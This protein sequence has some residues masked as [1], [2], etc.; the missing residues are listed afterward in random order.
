MP[1]RRHISPAAIAPPY[2]HISHS[3]PILLSLSDEK[4]QFHLNIAAPTGTL[5][6]PRYGQ[7]I[8]S[9]LA[10]LFPDCDPPLE[11]DNHVLED[12]VVSI[13][14]R[15]T[16]GCFSDGATELLR[17]LF[18]RDARRFVNCVTRN[19]VLGI[20]PTE[21]DDIQDAWRKVVFFESLKRRDVLEGIEGI[22][23]R[24]NV[25]EWALVLAFA[26]RVGINNYFQRSPPSSA[27][28]ITSNISTNS[29]TGATALSTATHILQ[30]HSLHSNLTE[31]LTP[32]QTQA[33]F[34][35]HT[36]DL[37]NF[38]LLA[39]DSDSD[40]ATPESVSQLDS[41][42]YAVLN[43]AFHLCTSH[44]TTKPLKFNGR[45]ALAA[46]S[47]NTNLDALSAAAVSALSAA[48]A[49]EL[50]NMTG[51][52][53]HEMAGF[54]KSVGSLGSSLPGALTDPATLLRLGP[55]LMANPMLLANPMGLAQLALSPP[56]AGMGIGMGYGALGNPGFNGFNGFNGMPMSPGYGHGLSPASASPFFNSSLNSPGSSNYFGS[57]NTYGSTPLTIPS[58]MSSPGL[59]PFSTSP[60]NPRSPVFSLAETLSPLTNNPLA[61]SVMSN[62]LVASAMANP[63]ML[64]NP[65]TNPLAMAAVTPAGLPI[66]ALALAGMMA[67]NTF[68]ASHSS[69][70]SKA[71]AVPISPP[72]Q[73]TAAASS[74]SSSTATPLSPFLAGLSSHP[75][76]QNLPN[77]PKL[78][79]LPPEM[80][81]LTANLKQGLNQTVSSLSQP[82]GAP[83]DPLGTPLFQSLQPILF[84]MFEVAWDT[85]L[86][87]CWQLCRRGEAPVLEG[88]ELRRWVLLEDHA[89]VQ[90]MEALRGRV[91]GVRA[92]LA[93]VQLGAPAETPEGVNEGAVDIPGVPKVVIEAP[94]VPVVPAEAG[95]GVQGAATVA[96]PVPVPVAI[97]VAV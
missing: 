16:G 36:Q 38:L 22:G 30:H 95:V 69:S 91:E 94:A 82:F 14:L 64:A 58:P 20:S 76:L 52:Q 75:L 79:N 4:K 56:G 2:L 92:L 32:E 68:N 12:D 51:M 62:P 29:I 83:L 49:N 6:R 43:T 25:P 93:G 57:P 88:E 23:E 59:S 77:L 89:G 71:P 67:Y 97:P 60:L 45:A 63:L 8:N 47:N 46:V 37:L 78:P 13:A 81:T 15:H 48:G 1:L 42:L 7:K 26:V 70:G 27:S 3:A 31:K 11:Y 50:T 65:L 84:A 34:H 33:L 55:S 73:K 87:M 19:G 39:L 86:M 28:S 54:L 96:V 9:L 35:S 24:E 5:H 72:T 53:P 80:A 61:A 44:T 74:S 10:D 21:E 17:R 66:A 90:V 41:A 40:A 85:R 18:S